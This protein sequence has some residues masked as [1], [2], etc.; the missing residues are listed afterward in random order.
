MRV[1]GITGGVATGKSTVMQMFAALGAPIL[2]ADT[3]AHG[4][5]EPGTETY[6]QVRA[7]FALPGS[8][9]AP[10][11]RA[12]LGQIV[13]ADPQARQRLE[14][15]THPPI[16]AALAAQTAAWRAQSG[17][18]AAAEIPLL[19]EVGLESLC[20]QIIVVACAEDVQRARLRQRLGTRAAETEQILAA[21]W[22]L[23]QKIARAHH[24]IT[25]DLGRE[26]TQR[27]VGALWDTLA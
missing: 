2:S 3:L 16:I 17:K 21:Q 14:A 18:A 6:R 15:I 8:V 27:Q 25:T 4:L 11:D 12:A 22:P 19:F 7:A 24:V 20:D 13:F 10:L 26:D 5:L 9:N 1:L 23:A